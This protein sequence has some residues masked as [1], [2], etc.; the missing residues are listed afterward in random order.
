MEEKLAYEF[1][2]D[3]KFLRQYYRLRK[4]IY[5]IDL[6]MNIPAQEDYYDFLSETL[7]VRKKQHC[8]GGVRLTVCY[9]NSGIMLPTE[10]EDF[11]LGDLFP[12]LD[13]RNNAYAEFSRLVLR[14]EYR[15]NKVS[16][17][18]YKQLNRKA[19]QLGVRYI[20]VITDR[21][22]ARLY[23]RSYRKLGFDVKILNVPI[24]D[25]IKEKY[26]DVAECLIMLDLTPKYVIPFINMSSNVF[27]LSMH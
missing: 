11:C 19:R 1:T 25:S 22:R 15:N 27:E 20:F 14:R 5:D 18:M 8:V 23:L 9:P 2:D 13:L 16:D 7:I 24:P 4:I 3:I 26:E 12:E 21:L 10:N 6:G 17:I